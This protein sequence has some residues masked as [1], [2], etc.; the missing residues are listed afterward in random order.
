MVYP[1]KECKLWNYWW[2]KQMNVQIHGIYIYFM[3]KN[4]SVCIWHVKKV[5]HFDPFLQP[6]QAF[7]R[8]HISFEY[9]QWPI[10]VAY[11][12]LKKNITIKF[13]QC[14]KVKVLNFTITYMVPQ[15]YLTYT[16]LVTLMIWILQCTIMLILGFS[17]KD[18][19]KIFFT[20][21]F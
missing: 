10:V 21:N 19:L 12:L 15:P 2:Y 6:S 1:L 5:L 18:I 16:M 3:Q 20:Y 13:F 11:K 17:F 9:S 4:Q 14:N 8:L 7:D